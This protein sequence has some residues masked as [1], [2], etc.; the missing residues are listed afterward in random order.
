MRFQIG[1]NV[2]G[3][4]GSARPHIFGPDSTVPTF[5][6]D[7]KANNWSQALLFYRRNAP[8][9]LE[10]GNWLRACFLRPDN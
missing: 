4:S 9:C 6:T 1:I 8:F 10:P 2:V 5:P 3:L 7:S